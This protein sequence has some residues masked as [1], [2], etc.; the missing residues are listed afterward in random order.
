MV[1]IENLKHKH[2]KNMDH[3]DYVPQ[4]NADPENSV[5]YRPPVVEVADPTSTSTSTETTP[6]YDEI[7]ETPL[8]AKEHAHEKKVKERQIHP[9]GLRRIG[10]AAV[11]QI[12]IIQGAGFKE[13][14]RRGLDVIKNEIRL[15]AITPIE[16]MKYTKKARLE[17]RVAARKNKEIRKELHRQKVA[18]GIRAIHREN[19]RKLDNARYGKAA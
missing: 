11:T 9:K 2:I 1:S 5:G 16:A 12:Q 3:E 17:R 4:A 13:S 19:S 18:E 14:A 7:D 8:E 15:R 6:S 10:E